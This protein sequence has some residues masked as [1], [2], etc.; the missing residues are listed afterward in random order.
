MAL[1]NIVERDGHKKRY[2][3]TEIILNEEWVDLWSFKGI[4]MK[5]NSLKEVQKKYLR[6][7]LIDSRIKKNNFPQFIMSVVTNFQDIHL[8]YSLF[9]MIFRSF[10]HKLTCLTFHMP[11]TRRQDTKNNRRWTQWPLSRCQHQHLNSKSCAW[12]FYQRQESLFLQLF[13][14]SSTRYE[15]G[16][17]RIT[18]KKTRYRPKNLYF[19]EW[20]RSTRRIY[21]NNNNNNIHHQHE[22][23]DASKASI[24]R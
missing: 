3:S 8:L 23:T 18:K 13:F 24:W 6:T 7:F 15:G 17:K 16:K 4:F 2:D 1:G 12:F 20:I 9:Y 11:N 19:S 5:N 21:S 22:A 10:R 14:Y